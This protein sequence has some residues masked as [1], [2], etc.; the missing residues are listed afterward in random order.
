M[1]STWRYPLWRTYA[2][3]ETTLLLPLLAR[4]WVP[5]GLS[6]AKSL[7]CFSSQLSNKS[8]V[9]RANTMGDAR[10]SKPTEVTMMGTG[11][12][13]SCSCWIACSGWSTKGPISTPKS[14]SQSQISIRISS[15]L[16]IS[17]R[18]LNYIYMEATHKEK[19]HMVLVSITCPSS[20]LKHT[21]THPHLS[22]PW[23]DRE[24][25]LHDFRIACHR[26]HGFKQLDG[27]LVTMTDT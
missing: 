2:H 12:S 9:N 20:A 26:I 23:L 11:S 10:L 1:G 21:H 25:G 22:L 15:W 6:L 19:H 17:S 4:S 16:F 14:V 27:L 8:E 13:S 18:D 5:T 24:G 7:P 3:T